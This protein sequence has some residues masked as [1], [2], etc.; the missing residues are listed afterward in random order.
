MLT[1]TRAG[2][3]EEGLAFTGRDSGSTLT[4]TRGET[5]ISSSSFGDFC[6]L[7]G[8]DSGEG[9]LAFLLT[10]ISGMPVRLPLNVNFRFRVNRD[11]C[12]RRRA[13]AHGLSTSFVPEG[14]GDA[15]EIWLALSGK[16]V[17][18]S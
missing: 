14:F 12:F 3:D 2:S 4:G 5:T 15:S 7:V 9:S 8:L 10:T 16:S 17:E 1:G 6:R 18:P 11:L 13:L